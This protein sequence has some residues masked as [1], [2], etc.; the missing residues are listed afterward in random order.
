MKLLSIPPFCTPQRIIDRSNLLQFPVLPVI[1]SVRKENGYKKIEEYGRGH[2]SS[3]E[4][5][6]KER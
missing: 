5:T 6:D 2:S 3:E 1:L 4:E